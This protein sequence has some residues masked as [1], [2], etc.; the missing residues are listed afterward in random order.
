[1]AYRSSE[2]GIAS[3]LVGSTAGAGASI[4]FD[5]AFLSSVRDL[6]DGPLFREAA[7][8]DL[9]EFLGNVRMG[10]RSSRRSFRRRLFALL[11]NL[12][13]IHPGI[14]LCRDEFVPV[15]RVHC[16]Y[17]LGQPL[18]QCVLLLLRHAL[19]LLAGLLV[20]GMETVLDGFVLSQGF[21][22]DIDHVRGKSS[23]IIHQ[24]AQDQGPAG[25][26]ELFPTNV[27]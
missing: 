11:A 9:M 24:V 4:F 5:A 21:P 15:F 12:V 7:R 23:W 1:M 19:D 10:Q 22:S 17:R 16:Q 26:A 3:I 2:T 14:E 25:D 20:Q 8:Y 13:R 18:E 27:W 6:L